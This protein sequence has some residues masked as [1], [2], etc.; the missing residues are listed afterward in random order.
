[1]KKALLIAVA[2]LMMIPA[3]VTA[4]EKFLGLFTT[5]YYPLD[6]EC[7]ITKTGT[8]MSFNYESSTIIFHRD[9]AKI[10]RKGFNALVGVKVV[11]LR[12]PVVIGTPVF[13][14]CQNKKK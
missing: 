12:K 8:A 2:S 11:N 1:M 6:S 3:A 4:E 5:E 13:I 14:Q 10:T 9:Q 7:E